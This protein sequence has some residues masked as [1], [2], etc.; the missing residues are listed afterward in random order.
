MAEEKVV[1]TLDNFEQ[2]LMVSVLADFLNELSREEK[3][4]EGVEELMRWEDRV[5]RWASYAE[6]GESALR[7]CEERI[8]SARSELS[9]VAFDAS[10][11]DRLEARVS[12]L[13]RECSGLRRS[14]EEA[15]SEVS[16]SV[17]F[18]YTDPEP[19]FD[20]SRVKGVVAELIE[21]REERYSEAVEVA[22]GGQR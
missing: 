12:G 17:Q 18:R 6:R 14:L 20:R 11:F 5:M 7:A 19:G 8:Q 3:R 21:V 16:S 10:E 4:T 15:E 13:E 22:A 1:V 2:R 9:S